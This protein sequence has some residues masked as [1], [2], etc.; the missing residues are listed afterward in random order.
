MGRALSI[1]F[2]GFSTPARNRHRTEGRVI[3]D[4]LPVTD[5]LLAL[6][7]AVGACHGR[8]GCNSASATRYR[9]S[10]CCA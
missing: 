8:Y 1:V 6:S 5:W 10:V 3:P 7:S 2:L 4:V 9:A